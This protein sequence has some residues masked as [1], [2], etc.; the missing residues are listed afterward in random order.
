MKHELSRDEALSIHRLSEDFIER[1]HRTY[2]RYNNND[3]AFQSQMTILLGARGVGKTTLMLQKLVEYFPD[4]PRKRLFLPIDHALFTDV[5]LYGIIA[6]FSRNGAEMICIDEIHKYPSWPKDLKSIRDEFPSLKI[7]VSGS[8]SIEIQKSSRDLSRRAIVTS[9]FGLSFREFLEL[10]TGA[11]IAPIKLIDL[12]NNHEAIAK[13]VLSVLKNISTKITLEDYFQKYLRVGYYPY[14]LEYPQESL[15]NLTLIQSIEVTLEAEIPAQNPKINYVATMRFKRL[16]GIVATLPPFEFELKKI[17]LLTEI[18]DE[19]TLKSYLRMLEIG[20]LI[21]T[22]NRA[23]TG[24]KSMRKP[25]KIYLD[26][27]N[28]LQALV[29]RTDAANRGTIRELFFLMST[30]VNHDLALAESGDFTLDKKFT[31]EVGGQKKTHRQIHH[32]KNA[33]L[34]KDDIDV[35]YGDAIPLWMFGFLY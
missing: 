28:L 20:G 9:M 22:M 8:S 32:V 4:E 10:T 2:R 25:D 30:R 3:P 18:A 29:P 33:Y 24:L 31:F 26:N 16:L 11:E 17:L 15:F 6:Y 1:N 27:T 35:G 23:A 34:V 14:H 13:S 5:S 21:I 19:R 7:I 12:L